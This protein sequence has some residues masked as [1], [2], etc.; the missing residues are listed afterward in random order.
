LVRRSIKDAASTTKF[1][2][3]RIS[4]KKIY[5]PRDERD[6]GSSGC[7]VYWKVLLRYSDGENEENHTKNQLG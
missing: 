1:I 4:L 6:W 5:V 7:V 2:W 3:R